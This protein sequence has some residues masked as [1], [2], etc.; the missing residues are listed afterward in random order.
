M[1]KLKS[2]NRFLLY[3]QL[4]TQSN[5][6][7]FSTFIASIIFEF[8]FYIIKSD[9][10]LLVNTFVLFFSLLPIYLNRKS[11][12]GLASLI[13]LVIMSLSAFVNSLVFGL[14]VGFGF[15]FFNYAGLIIY[16]NWKPLYKLFAIVIDALLLY[17]LYIYF[18]FNV[19]MIT[20]SNELFY[21]FLVFNIV[22]NIVGIAHSAYFYMN[23][24]MI[25]TERLSYLSTTDL[26]TGLLNRSAFIEEFMIF[27][28]NPKKG[29]GLIMF[30]IDFFKSINDTYGHLCGDSVLSKLGSLLKENMGSDT[31]MGRYGGEEFILTFY[32]ESLD[33]VNILAEKVRILIEEYDF[34][35][36]KT[37]IKTTI[38]V[39]AVY[40]PN[41]V[42]HGIDIDQL[43]AQTDQLLYLSKQNGRNL[44][45]LETFK[46][47]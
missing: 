46:F 14:N 16:T 35:H 41:D 42:N 25:A 8:V 28:Q 30:D 37:L 45:S 6:V 44:V 19:E 3:K 2:S 33:D 32:C 47:D 15:Y 5:I 4:Y 9:F 13:Y 31:L 23:N 22:L 24:A 43:L 27:C 40:Y 21:T 17:S 29:I 11:Y 20:L 10:A 39:G 38:S 26:L 12:Y 7:Y 36:N 34:N 18:I 1:D